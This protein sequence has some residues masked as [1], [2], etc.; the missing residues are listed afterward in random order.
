MKPEWFVASGNG[1]VRCRVQGKD[2]VLEADCFKM[3]IGRTPKRGWFVRWH[4]SHVGMSRVKG[5][6]WLEPE[7]L[8]TMFGLQVPNGEEDRFLLEKF[9]A[10]AARR[11]CYVR[12]EDYLCIP[13][14]GHGY[15]GDMTA[16]VVLTPS[17]KQAVR[18]ILPTS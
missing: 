14:P 10:D 15:I 3:T 12:Q 13:A 11:G 16:S 8:K 4:I 18:S 9:Q 2:V 7:T 17:I 5:Q 1:P 6:L